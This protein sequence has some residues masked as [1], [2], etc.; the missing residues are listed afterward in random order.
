VSYPQK[1]KEKW[2]KTTYDFDVAPGKPDDAFF[3]LRPSC[4][5]ID[6]AGGVKG[7]TEAGTGRDGGE[8]NEEVVAVGFVE[9]DG[10][11]GTRHPS[12]RCARLE[13]VH[14][15]QRDETEDRYG[16]ASASRPG[17]GGERSGSRS[18]LRFVVPTVT[19]L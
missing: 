18:R 19:E 14:I 1:E 5:E 8:V 7:R 2:R 15:V 11:G 6:G 10:V 13:A 12:A 16:S 4:A 17:R 3:P 9:E